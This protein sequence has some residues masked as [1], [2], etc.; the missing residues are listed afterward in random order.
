MIRAPDNPIG[1]RERNSG[2][3]VPDAGPL[4]PQGMTQRYLPGHSPC[5]E[6]GQS[7]PSTGPCEWCVDNLALKEYLVTFPGFGAFEGPWLVS[8]YTPSIYFCQFAYYWVAGVCSYATVKGMSVRVC[9]GFHFGIHVGK[10]GDE[11]NHY[12]V[13]ASIDV[14]QPGEGYCAGAR[15]ANCTDAE[16]DCINYNESLSLWSCTEPDP[17]VEECTFSISCDVGDASLVGA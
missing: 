11:N 5:C 12:I 10:C 14:V 2:L 8:A 6:N 9:G 1:F 17:P 7:G 3:F 15:Y 16:I 13:S 4:Y